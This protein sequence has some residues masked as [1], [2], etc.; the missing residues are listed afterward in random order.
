MGIVPIENKRG[1]GEQY[2]TIDGIQIPK[3]D[4]LLYNGKSIPKLTEFKG[5]FIYNSRSRDAQFVIANKAF[6]ASK[7]H[8]I[9]MIGA[10][11]DNDILGQQ[12]LYWYGDSLSSNL[13]DYTFKPDATKG[14][15]AIGE[16]FHST[17]NISTLTGI[18]YF[19]FGNSS[20]VTY[21]PAYSKITQGTDYIEFTAPY[22]NTGLRNRYK[23]VWLE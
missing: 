23:H 5:S 10:N 14:G 17:A 15:S 2:I 21:N 12:L 1:S 7:Y 6:N 18:K 19:G 22:S 16:Y 8:T 11:M 20:G 3:K 13:T 4:V 9:H